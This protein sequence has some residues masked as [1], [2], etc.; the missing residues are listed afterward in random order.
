MNAFI[1]NTFIFGLGAATGAFAAIKLLEDHY[2]QMAEEE[3]NEH[4]EYTKKKIDEVIAKYEKDNKEVKEVI[5]KTEDVIKNKYAKLAT[6][7]NSPAQTK[8]NLADMVENIIEQTE[9]PRE[10]DDYDELEEEMYEKEAESDG[11]NERLDV[12]PYLITDEEFTNE[13][14]HYEKLTLWYYELDQT[15]ADDNEEII[16]NVDQLIG[17]GTLDNMVDDER[18]IYIRNDRQGADFEIICLNKSYKEE[19]L[20][21]EVITNE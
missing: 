1:K 13:N 5:N 19:V 6:N 3:V 15:L 7:Y 4:R 2:A 10:D 11:L 16:D 21:E 20:G 12:D 8:P 18:T 14:R 17:E 9:Y